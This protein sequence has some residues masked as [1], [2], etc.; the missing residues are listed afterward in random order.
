MNIRLLFARIYKNTG[1]IYNLKFLHVLLFFLT[2]IVQ[3]QQPL[4]NIVVNRS[5]DLSNN[6]IIPT[7]IY[8]EGTPII[9][10][11]GLGGSGFEQFLNTFKH[12][13]KRSGLLI[14]YKKKY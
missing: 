12:S 7:K 4:S 1:L 14:V 2:A 5:F 6:V 9:I 11:P 3:A 8:G 10:L 13:T